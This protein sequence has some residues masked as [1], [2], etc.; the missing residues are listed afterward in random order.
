MFN[1]GGPGKQRGFG[2]GGFSMASKKETPLQPKTSLQ[3]SRSHGV[4]SKT[5]VK[6]ALPEKRR[7]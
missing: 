3:Q 4:K 7:T 6:Q 1:K 5:T 2:F